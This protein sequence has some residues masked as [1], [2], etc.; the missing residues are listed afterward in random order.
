MKIMAFVLFA[1]P[2]MSMAAPRTLQTPPNISTITSKDGPYEAAYSN[3][4]RYRMTVKNA[5]GGESSQSMVFEKF[6][7]GRYGSPDKVIFSKEVSVPSLPTVKTYIDGVSK[8]S[9]EAT[10]QCCEVSDIT[11]VDY[12]VRFNVRHDKK[13]FSC[14][15]GDFS[16]E[17]F[18][19][20]CKE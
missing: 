8:S 1:S 13:S 4:V 17:K 5:L 16:N 14:E 18:K 12:K 7:P 15:A 2:L 11:W 19:V 20:T 3:A 9:A 10:Y 6:A